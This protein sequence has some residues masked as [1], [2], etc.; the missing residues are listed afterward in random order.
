MLTRGDVMQG[1]YFLV[2]DLRP[3][4][5]SPDETDV[6]FC[7]RLTIDARVTLIPASPF[8]SPNASLRQFHALAVGVD[9]R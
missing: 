9:N 3:L 5:V 6:D 4:A 1:T 7:R 2:A 8:P